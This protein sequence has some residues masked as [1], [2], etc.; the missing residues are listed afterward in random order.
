MRL[1][2]VASMVRKASRY[3]LGYNWIGRLLNDDENF[4]ED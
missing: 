2:L 4:E 3:G 1:K